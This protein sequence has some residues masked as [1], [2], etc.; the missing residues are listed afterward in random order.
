MPEI[1][2]FAPVKI[3]IRPDGVFI[4]SYEAAT[5][6]YRLEAYKPL[7][8]SLKACQEAIGASQALV[9]GL[10][11]ELTEVYAQLALERDLKAR[12]EAQVK[13]DVLTTILTAGGAG[14]AIG[15]IVGCVLV[16]IIKK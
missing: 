16:A 13:K 15:I 9:V 7:S 3:E 5:A 10:R 11:G 8:F 1:T 4:A 2:N 6:L 14:M 12:R